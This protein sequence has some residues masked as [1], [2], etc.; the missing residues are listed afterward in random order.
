MKYELTYDEGRDLIIGHIYGE[1]TSSL[2]TK[3]A[4][5]LAGMIRKHNFGVAKRSS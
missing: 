1:F 2:V 3:M 5:D 4:S